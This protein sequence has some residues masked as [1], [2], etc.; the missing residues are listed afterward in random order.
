[1]CDNQ[2]IVDAINKTSVRGESINPLQLILL[3][4]ASFD[5][6]IEARWLS[7]EENWIAHSLSRFDLKR[8]ANFK[9]D[10]IFNMPFHPSPSFP[11]SHRRTGP[12]LAALRQR[13][14][15]YYGTE[16]PS[17]PGLPTL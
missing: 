5:I 2:A 11:P 13:L 4:A 16:L 7:S 1:M 6:D 17:L 9:L 3:A 10:L 8:L 15:D 12:Q 14:Q